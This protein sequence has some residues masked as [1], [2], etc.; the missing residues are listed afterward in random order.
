MLHATYLAALAAGS[1]HATVVVRT[2]DW[3]SEPN[4]RAGATVAS[5]ESRALARCLFSQSQ[6]FSRRFPIPELRSTNER[7]SRPLFPSP[8]SHPT[9]KTMLYSNC[10]SLAVLGAAVSAPAAAASEAA[11]A[12]EPQRLRPHARDAQAIKSNDLGLFDLDLAGAG[13]TVELIKANPESMIGTAAICEDEDACRAASGSYGTFYAGDYGYAGNF[14]CFEKNGKAFW[15]RG[16]TPAQNEAAMDGAK[17]RIFCPPTTSS[18]ASEGTGGNLD[19]SFPAA[20]PA[21]E[22][23]LESSRD[24]DDV[25]DLRGK[26]SYLPAAKEGDNAE[27]GGAARSLTGLL[28]L[29]ALGAAL[30]AVAS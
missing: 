9:P 16:G 28:S 24:E 6:I 30:W 17:M 14:G 21:P 26:D 5:P 4:S 3:R 19:L 12:A 20:A 11:A 18:V 22:P 23:E 7:S 25:S 15:G 8:T 13:G 29:T 27:N 2:P 1:C 10:V